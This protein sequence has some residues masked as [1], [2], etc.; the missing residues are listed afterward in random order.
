MIIFIYWITVLEKKIKK[1]Y[2]DAAA[3]VKKIK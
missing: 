2:D 1:S 3:E